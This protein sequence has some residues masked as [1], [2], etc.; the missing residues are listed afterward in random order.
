M[1]A[2]WSLGVAFLAAS[3]ILIILS[4]KEYKKLPAE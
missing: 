3:I 2:V 1:A 4:I